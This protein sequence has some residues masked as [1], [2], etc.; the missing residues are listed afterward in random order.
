MRN[1]ISAVQGA[2]FGTPK[3]ASASPEAASGS[4]EMISGEGEMKSDALGA[5]HGSWHW[6]PH[7]GSLKRLQF[8]FP[9]VAACAANALLVIPATHGQCTYSL[10]TN[11]LGRLPP[12]A[13]GCMAVAVTQR[14]YSLN[15][16]TSCVPCASFS[17]PGGTACGV[18]SLPSSSGTIVSKYTVLCQPVGYVTRISTACNGNMS[19]FIPPCSDR[20]NRLQYGTIRGDGTPAR[21]PLRIKTVP[22]V[23]G[24]R[25][26]LPGTVQLFRWGLP[27][28]QYRWR[29]AETSAL[30]V[31]GSQPSG[32]FVTGAN[33]AAMTITSIDTPDAGLYVLEAST[34]GG[35]TYAMV[36]AVR[37]YVDRPVPNIVSM[38][39]DREACLGGS[40]DFLVIA[41]E[42]SGVPATYRWYRNGVPITDG[43]QGGLGTVTG[44]T[45]P[46]LTISNLEAG[47]AGN[48]SCHIITSAYVNN[49]FD[50][51][52]TIS[53][54]ATPPVVLAP[55]QSIAVDAGQSAYM[56]ADVDVA[57]GQV[58]SFQWRKNGLPIYDDGRI[59]G[60]Q[61]E[62]LLFNAAA[63]SDVGTYDCIVTRGCA[64]TITAAATL[65]VSMPI[66]CDDIDFN[67]NEVFPEDQDIVDYLDVLAGGN[68][69]ACNDID[70][71]NNG[72]F[73]EDQDVVDFFNVLAG[74][75]C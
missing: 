27:T 43:V 39:Q 58:P 66:V 60:T 11:I 14:I 57:T 70:F 23:G 38:P 40:T 52:L 22:V 18:F 33:S 19:V 34:N 35:G 28:E 44:A 53:N 67:N 62:Q 41:N 10:S 4:P 24:V 29:K 64:T 21:V 56:I 5:K 68:C 9:S 31:N 49:T 7:K 65:N 2:I 37:V 8:R 17:F 32:S 61:T 3:H 59:E 47:A 51:A 1:L 71:N 45:T 20:P 69:P 55:P 30:I 48:Y 50:A 6:D 63:M 42:P 13:G 16:D 15:G 75:A 26:F 25:G 73:P 74:G 36:D 72:V 46:M 54:N 12:S